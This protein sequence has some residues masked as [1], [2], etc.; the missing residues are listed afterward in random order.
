MWMQKFSRV[1]SC[2]VILLLIFMQSSDLSVSDE[3]ATNDLKLY[4][5]LLAREQMPYLRMYQML[6]GQHY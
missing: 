5:L 4:K 3:A 2:L 6:L 1:Y